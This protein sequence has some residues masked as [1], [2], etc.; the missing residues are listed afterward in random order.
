M[1]ST[2]DYYWDNQEKFDKNKT[3]SDR[4]IMNAKSGILKNSKKLKY[5]W[6]MK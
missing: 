2:T 3:M 6:M 4:E 5:I 1:G